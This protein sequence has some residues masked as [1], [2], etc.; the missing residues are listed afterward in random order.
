[1][2]IQ[3]AVDISSDGITKVVVDD[4]VYSWVNQPEFDPGT[5]PEFA[6]V[7]NTSAGVGASP[8]LGAAGAIVVGDE[9]NID[10]GSIS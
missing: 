4:A 6:L 9:A 7:I 5:E 10:G 3:A 2:V 8:L 1:M